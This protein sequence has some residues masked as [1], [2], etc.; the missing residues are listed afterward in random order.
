[1]NQENP[2]HIETLE[3]VSNEFVTR[4]PKALVRRD[5]RPRE[6]LESFDP[7]SDDEKSGLQ[8]DKTRRTETPPSVPLSKSS[9]TTAKNTTESSA[10][11]SSALLAPPPSVLQSFRGKPID[12]P[13]DELSEDMLVK[14]KKSPPPKMAVPPRA[15]SLGRKSE[16]VAARATNEEHQPPLTKKNTSGRAD[17]MSR[18]AVPPSKT[19]AKKTIVNAPPKSA[20]VSPEKETKETATA[21]RNSTATTIT[22]PLAVQNQA[23]KV[24]EASKSEAQNREI[25]IDLSASRSLT[26]LVCALSVNPGFGSEVAPDERRESIQNLMGKAHELTDFICKK[27]KNGGNVPNYLYGS[28]FQEATRHI[29]HSWSNSESLDIEP[30]KKT[31]GQFFNHDNPLLDAFTYKASSTS[32]ANKLDGQTRAEL[33]LQSALMGAMG[34][35]RTTVLSMRIGKFIDGYGEQIEGLRERFAMR[36]YLFGQNDDAKIVSDLIQSAFRIAEENKINAIDEEMTVQ[37]NVSMIYRAADLVKSEYEMF[38]ERLI[39]SSFED[40]SLHEQA[41]NSNNDMYEV[42]LKNIEKRA[43]ESFNMIS[44]TARRL[45]LAPIPAQSDVEPGNINTQRD[46]P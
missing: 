13:L 43:K 6:T 34:N 16:P 25:R 3:E 8:A 40:V 45:A 39:R 22:P 2:A 20:A 30:A 27:I 15:L 46:K 14:D 4:I 18:F 32:E 17:Q 10:K 11:G 33:A 42:A 37:W 41:L 38:V 9:R 24:R 28:I 7:L 26:H 35:I 44:R 19:A 1:M 36:S 21:A 12:A 29:A 5:A 31:A 23:D